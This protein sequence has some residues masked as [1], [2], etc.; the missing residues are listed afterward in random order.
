MYSKMATTKRTNKTENS[1]LKKK[2][3]ADCSNAT[4]RQ[5]ASQY[6]SVEIPKESDG[7]LRE[8]VLHLQQ[9]HHTFMCRKTTPVADPGGAPRA[10]AP[11][12]VSP[13]G[14][15]FLLYTFHKPQAHSP[16][17]KHSFLTHMLLFMTHFQLMSVL[18][19]VTYLQIS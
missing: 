8:L 18:L 6:I 15:F 3:A 2:K 1:S 17:N 16:Q 13:T 4:G 14:I 11:P 19:K 7:E 12:F 5:V 10:I 9:H